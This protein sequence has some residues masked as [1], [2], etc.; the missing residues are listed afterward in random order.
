M[1]VYEFHERCE[2]GRHYVADV[3]RIHDNGDKK[4]STHGRIR[5]S[6]TKMLDST[7]FTIWGE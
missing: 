5:V 3:C 4:L 7:R 6:L 2:S 1:K